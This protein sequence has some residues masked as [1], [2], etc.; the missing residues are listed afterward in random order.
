MR[1]KD[2]WKKHRMCKHHVNARTKGYYEKGARAQFDRS[3]RTT[4]R[5]GDSWVH[6]RRPVCLQ[7][8]DRKRCGCSNTQEVMK[9]IC[10]QVWGRPLPRYWSVIPLDLPKIWTALVE[11]I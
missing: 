8:R 7:G 1:N 5:Y 3:M 2:H 6:S 9:L 10:T 11:A 4:V